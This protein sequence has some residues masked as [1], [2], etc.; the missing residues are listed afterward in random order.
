ML[1]MLKTKAVNHRT[2]TKRILTKY[3]NERQRK[4]LIAIPYT[5]TEG[6]DSNNNKLTKIE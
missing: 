3:I 5:G 1:K 6:I 4:F 2:V